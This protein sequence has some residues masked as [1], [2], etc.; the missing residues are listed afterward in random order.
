MLNVCCAIYPV[1][2]LVNLH[3]NIIVLKSAKRKHVILLKRVTFWVVISYS[4]EI[5]R[6]F[7]G[8]CR[9]HLQSWQAASY[10]ACF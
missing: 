9:L 4:S 3:I 2:W 1:T 10:A 8:I 6:C 7:E 5:T